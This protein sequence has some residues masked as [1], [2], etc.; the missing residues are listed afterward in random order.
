MKLIHVALGVV[1]ASLLPTASAD[2]PAKP[3]PF[4][5]SFSSDVMPV[6][7]GIATY[8]TYA[9]AR[10]LTGMCEVTF[11]VNTSG[12]ADAIRVG[13]CTSEG[14]RR[15]AKKTV[16]TMTFAPRAAPLDHVSMQIRWAIYNDAPVKT[17]SID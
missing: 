17:A 1:A 9:G 16:E 6:S 14:L 15:S 12:K 10:D 3:K 4:I 13:A 7:H 5:I 11:A 2:E 8:P